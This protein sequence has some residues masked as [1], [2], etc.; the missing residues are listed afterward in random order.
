MTDNQKGF[1]AIYLTVL[2]LAT[3]G[4]FAKGLPISSLD[5]TLIRSVIAAIVLVPVVFIF[6]IQ[7]KISAYR[8]IYI[9]SGL[10]ILLSLHWVT[11]FEAMRVST[12]AIGMTMLYTYPVFTVILESVITKHKIQRR[13]V[14]MSLLVVLGIYIISPLHQ[15]SGMALTGVLWGLTSAVLFA[16]RNVAQ[17]HFCA[18]LSPITAVAIQCVSG[19]LILL[20]FASFSDI[21]TLDNESI[22]ALI[23]LGV[24]FTAF[25]HAL[26]A[27]SL[28][29]L[30][31]KTVAFVGCLQ[32]VFGAFIALW[33]LGEIPGWNV[34]IGGAIILSVAAFETRLAAPEKESG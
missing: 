27:T 1:A 20:P 25:A 9:L 18:H 16:L 2:L 4:L 5:T 3:N 22:L 12:V 30:K 6:R 23:L 31:A 33:V 34:I 10:G 14:L 26:L 24:V 17:R 19:A 29:F 13:D 32:P 7:K 8:D 28:Q 15:G 21:K 11:F